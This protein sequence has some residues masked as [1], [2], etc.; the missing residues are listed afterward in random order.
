MSRPAP[1]FRRTRLP[2]LVLACVWALSGCDALGVETPAKTAQKKEAEGRAIGS[3]CRYSVRNIEDCYSSNPKASK[4][5]IFDG[6][7]EMDAYMRENEIAGMPIKGAEPAPVAPSSAPAAPV[8]EIV[9]PSGGSTATAPAPN[10]AAA[11]SGKA[12]TG[13]VDLPTLPGRPNIAP[14]G[15]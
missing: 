3:A 11:P 12:G 7:R 10:T 6:W 1:L 13:T 14:S 5:A 15:R 4:A 9:P 2:L 8:E